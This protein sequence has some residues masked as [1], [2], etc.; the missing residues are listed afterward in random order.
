MAEKPFKVLKIDEL[1]RLADG[2][3]VEKY[4]R[5]QI[6]TA[7]GVVISVDIEKA[8]FTPDKAGPILAARAANADAIKKL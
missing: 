1:T 6:K 7:G 8:D 3:G 4:Y 2:G 5:H